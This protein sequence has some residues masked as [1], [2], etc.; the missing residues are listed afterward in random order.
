[1][2]EEKPKQMS[3]AALKPHP[4]QLCFYDDSNAVDDESLAADLRRRGQQ[5][6]IVVMPENNAANLPGGTMLDGCRR[7]RCL[8]DSG[9]TDAMVVVRHDLKDASAAAVEAEFLKYNFTRRQ[10]HPLDKA[11]VAQR[12]YV[13]ERSK[14]TVNDLGFKE[15]LAMRDRIGKILGMSGR[16]LDR[17]LRVLETP[18][19]IQNAVR[20]GR[21]K[22]VMGAKIATLPQYEQEK[23]AEAITGVTDSKEVT[24]IAC[25]HV[26]ISDGR[27]HQK[28][29]DAVAC[30]ARTL[31]R[32]L[33]D[34]DGRVDQVGT[35]SVRR[36]LNTFV[37][38]Q[39]VLATLIAKAD[40][41]QTNTKA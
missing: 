5:S 22:L 20:D 30:F 41:D 11:R 2:N 17:Y 24:R 14:K 28:V 25:E 10:L 27:R 29:N 12:L 37:R 3:L 32:G 18:V 4:L 6:P 34:L 16:N 23:I 35:G 21:M 26:T 38:A 8:K 33:E 39:D 31:D 19:P 36:R 15:T 7:A 9:E 13:L 40:T 1:M